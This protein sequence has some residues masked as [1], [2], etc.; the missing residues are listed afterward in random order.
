MFRQ[1]DFKRWLPIFRTFTFLSVYICTF[2]ITQNSP[3]RDRIWESMF[4][5]LY[6]KSRRN[7]SFNREYLRKLVSRLN[8]SKENRY[9]NNTFLE[10]LLYLES[11]M[12][13][14]LSMSPRKCIYLVSF[15]SNV[16]LNL[17]WLALIYVLFISFLIR[18]FLF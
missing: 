15:L 8:I 2:T 4:L 11:N 7:K 13:P 3:Q 1:I 14:F 12:N 17:V 9:L 10:M 5:A 6:L 18:T 16:H